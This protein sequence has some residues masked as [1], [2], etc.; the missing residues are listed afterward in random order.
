MQVL[1][2][3]VVLQSQQMNY[4]LKWSHSSSCGFQQDKIDL[5]SWKIIC[6]FEPREIWFLLFVTLIIENVAEGNLSCLSDWFH[7][8]VTVRQCVYTLEQKINFCPKTQNW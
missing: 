8:I 4:F 2:Y 5:Q 7:A 6:D 3:V 1:Q